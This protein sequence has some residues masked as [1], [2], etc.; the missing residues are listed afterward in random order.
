LFL[1]LALCLVLNRAVLEGDEPRYLAFAQNLLKGFYS[2]PYPDIDLWNGPGY[3]LFLAPFLFLKIPV[4]AL[5]MLN[6]FLLY[7]SLI[8]TFKTIRSFS[9]SG[10]A[11]AFTCLLGLYYPVFEL[12]PFILTECFT[13]FLVSLVCFF[14]TRCFSSHEIRWKPLVITALLIAYL[15]MTKVIFGYVILVMIFISF[16]LMIPAGFRRYAKRSALLFLIS[17]GFCMPWLLYTHTYTGKFPYWSNSGGMSLYTMSSPFAEELGDWFTTAE[18]SVNPHHKDFID[19]ISK[20]TPLERDQA[21][22]NAAISNIKNHPRKYFSN[23]IAN[24]GRLL[25]SYP[26]SYSAQKISTLQTFLPNMFLVVLIALSLVAG[27]LRI[28]KF[29]AALIILFLFILV[30]LTGSSFVSAFRR[31]FYITLPFWCIFIA[32][33]RNHILTLKIND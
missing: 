26:H 7:F 6:A 33:V 24:V 1:Y 28:R 8:I 5:K 16:V 25:I 15:A 18:L 11:L 3:P 19:S 22:R 17:F 2:P 30:Y 4:L 21:Y 10:S 27:L 32:Y 9:S 13:W 12:L 23:W 14:L 31:M 20:L 29:P